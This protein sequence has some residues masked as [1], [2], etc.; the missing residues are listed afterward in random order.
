MKAANKIRKAIQENIIKAKNVKRRK[1]RDLKRVGICVTKHYNHL[2]KIK[3]FVFK[4]KNEFGE[5]VEIITTG[6][7]ESYEKKI[8]SYALQFDIKYKEFIPSHMQ[9]T[10]YAVGSS[11]FFGKE[12]SPKNFYIR[13]SKMAK[14]IDYLVVFESTK[15]KKERENLIKVVQ[16]LQKDVII[17][18]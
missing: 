18:I 16:K 1:K 8:K 11:S 9:K 2:R 17:V 3:D 10:L 5:K 15:D 14:Y 12:Y 13:D 6:N 7:T 4:L